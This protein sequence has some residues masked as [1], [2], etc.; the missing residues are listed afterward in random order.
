MSVSPAPEIFKA[1]DIRGLYPEQIDGD[2]AERI[3]NAFA[4]VLS[5]L[6]GKPI[7]ELRVGLGH[8][9]RLGAREL[10]ARY[11]EGLL[12]A[13]ADVL[14]IGE[15]ATEMPTEPATLVV[16]LPIVVTSPGLVV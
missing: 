4:V 2:L 6:A 14:D 13:G 1:Y 11:A 15:V 16:A 9:M 8:D 7:G 5:S 3:G 12:A 10:A